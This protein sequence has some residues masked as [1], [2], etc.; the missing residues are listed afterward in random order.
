M[1]DAPPTSGDP[2]SW[3]QSC[4]ERVLLGLESGRQH[5]AMLLEG[6]PGTGR[7]RFAEALAVHLLCTGVLSANEHST[8]RARELATAG[9]HPDLRNVAPEEAGK[10]I[11]IDAIRSAAAFV[12]AT[13]S[14]GERKVLLINPAERLT[15]AAWNAFL[16]CL[17]EPSPGTVI[18]MVAARGHPL[19]ATI[20]SRCQRI[21]LPSPTPAQ[22]LSWLAETLGEEGMAS[23]GMEHVLRLFA[24]QPLKAFAFN[25]SDD[26]GA[27]ADFFECF[28]RALS[29]GAADARTVLQAEAAAARLDPDN[30]LE[31]VES[32][33]AD[34]LRECPIDE[35]RARPGRCGFE[36]LETVAGLRRARRRGQNPN[37]DLLRSSAVAA[38]LGPVSL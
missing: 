10:A 13:P 28:D 14:L 4:W 22:A 23:R 31:A 11:G 7:A 35:L 16:K 27:L 3:H 20:R 33:L 9:S 15:L 38:L 1:A 26:L 25:D 2:L 6:L 12:N 29:H 32:T 19:P 21:H 36:A 18:I 24:V 8:G 37:A 5:H 30:L 17:E 34:R